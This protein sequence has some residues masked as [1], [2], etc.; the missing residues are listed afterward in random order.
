MFRKVSFCAFVS[1]LELVRGRDL[2]TML[3]EGLEMST[4]MTPCRVAII[5]DEGMVAALLEDMLA[6]LG[7][8]VVAIVGRMNPRSKSFL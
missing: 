3:R 7:H 2:K 1:S 4:E 8:E 5:E 6:D